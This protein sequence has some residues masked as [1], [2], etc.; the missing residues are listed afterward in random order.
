MNFVK[1]YN[2]IFFA[3][4]LLGTP[5]TIFAQSGVI[6][7]V[8]AVVGNSIVTKS[9]LESQYLQY[10]S[11]S[12]KTDPQLIRCKLLEQLMFQRLLLTQ[13]QKDS[14]VVTDAQVEQELDRRIRYFIS[15]FGSE[16]KFTEFYGKSVE[17]FKSDLGSDIKDLLLAQKM[18]AKLTE[19][20]AV[21]PSEIR[22]YYDKIPKDSLPFINEEVEIGQI[23]KKP[24]VSPEAKKEAKD[25]V[26]A[27]RDRIVNKGEDFAVLAALYSEDPGS[28]V[29]GGR[30][31]TLRRGAFVPEFEAAA[32]S[33]KLNEV[34]P[35]F[36][37]SYGYHIVELLD[38]R[39]EEISVRHIL[40]APKSSP[41]DLVKAGT[42]LDSIYTVIM[43][44]SI[45][46]RE[47]ASRF[48]DDE[49]SRQNGGLVTN[50]INGLTKFEKADLG[51]F[52]PTLAFTIDRMKPGEIT[53][54]S[55]TTTRDGK[56]VYRILNLKSR[57]EPH[58]ANLK[59]DYQ[60]IQTAALNEKHQ[61]AV[62]SWIRKHLAGTYI[63]ID[64]EY[65]GCKFD[66]NW[67]ANQ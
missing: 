41:N 30:Y 49:E 2:V 24:P 59:D 48:S 47:A 44:D 21:T 15:Q 20:M 43:R 65:K 63:R 6:D 66:I 29:R 3:A 18:Q 11:A 17:E 5:L 34:S 31:D 57:S 64:D 14:I 32:F 37:T 38:K 54:P 1:R 23:I 16:Q 39:G 42:I 12:D 33:L 60:K 52:D 7:K 19:D 35:V 25:R 67:L 36:E 61:K 22:S 26:Q 40:I 55:I 46:F 9:Q 58:A 8:I 45:S 27:L 10:A 51:Q 50:P 53:K 13:A 56:Q 62:T 4:L 28:A